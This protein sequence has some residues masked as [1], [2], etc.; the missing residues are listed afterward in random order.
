[1]T[2]RLRTTICGLHKVL[3]RA[4]LDMLHGSQLPSHRANL[5]LDDDGAV[6]KRSGVALVNTDDDNADNDD[7]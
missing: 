7:F 6:L 5:Q 3:F 2:P 4:G 1:M